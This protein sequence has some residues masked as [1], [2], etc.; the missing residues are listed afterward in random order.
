MKEETIHSRKRISGTFFL[1]HFNRLKS[2]GCRDLVQP[3]D[4]DVWIL[5]ES[6]RRKIADR[7]AKQPRP[8]YIITAWGERLTRLPIERRS[9]RCSEPRAVRPP[10][11]LKLPIIRGTRVVDGRRAELRIHGPMN[12]ILAYNEVTAAPDPGA[13][14]LQDWRTFAVSRRRAVPYIFDSLLDSESK[15]TFFYFLYIGIKRNNR[16]SGDWRAADW[17]NFFSEKKD[18]SF[19][20]LSLFHS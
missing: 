18:H 3:A 4:A 16:L 2:S 15:R 7:R 12:I 5:P 8:P 17:N 1:L 20:L 11:H 6:V 13:R 19:F 14:C 10:W 9:V